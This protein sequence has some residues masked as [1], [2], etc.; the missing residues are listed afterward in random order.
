MPLRGPTYKV[1][2]HVLPPSV[3]RYTPRSE[4]S[5]Y[6]LPVAPT[7]AVK[8]SC[9]DTNTLAIANVESNP[10]CAHDAPPSMDSHTPSPYELSLREFG[11]PV[12]TH[13]TRG[14]EGAIETAPIDATGL[15]P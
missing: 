9:G 10:R 11:S 7:R 4:E 3:V 5:R 1:F 15:L 2:A 12:P 13:T 6:G 14:F 8:G